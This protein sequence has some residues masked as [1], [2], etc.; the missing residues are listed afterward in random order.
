[1]VQKIVFQWDYFSCNSGCISWAAFWT[2]K[3]GA[4]TVE[5]K[6]ISRGFVG[7]MFTLCGKSQEYTA[8]ATQTLPK[9]PTNMNAH[10]NGMGWW[11]S[12]TWDD[13][14]ELW[15]IPIKL[16]SIKGLPGFGRGSLGHPLPI[17][18]R[19]QMNFVCTTLEHRAW[20]NRLMKTSRVV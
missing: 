11:W 2:V 5:L 16:S 4:T 18:A 1:M 19:D 14:H 7:E 6:L 9:F 3:N 17:L 8:I 20:K 13:H 12:L 15:E 10:M